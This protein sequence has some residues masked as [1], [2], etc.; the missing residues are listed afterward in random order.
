MTL[1]VEVVSVRLKERG[2]LTVLRG[3]W[4]Q[5]DITPPSMQRR[6]STGLASDK[7]KVKDTTL[8]FNIRKKQLTR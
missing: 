5:F 6:H 3:A 1:E 4:K 8:R 2:M 7:S